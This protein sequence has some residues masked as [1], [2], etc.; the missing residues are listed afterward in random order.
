MNKVIVIVVALVVLLVGAM[1]Y[2]GGQRAE[3]SLN[4]LVEHLNQTGNYP[5]A[6]RTYQNGWFK[7][8]G[9]LDVEIEA[10]TLPFIFTIHHGPLIVTDGIKVSWFSGE[11]HLSPEEEGWLREH[12]QVTEEGPL[13]QSRFS[14]GLTGVVEIKD[15]G[16]P[17]ILTDDSGVISVAGYRGEGELVRGGSLHYSGRLPSIQLLDNSNGTVAKF[18]ELSLSMTSDIS[19]RYGDH[20]IPGKARFSVG[21]I[22]AAGAFG[23]VSLDDLSF[24]TEATFN[25]ERTLA[26]LMI[27]IRLQNF[28]GYDEAVSNAVLKMGYERISLSF[29]DQYMQSMQASLTTGAEPPAGMLLMGLAMSDLIP[30]GPKFS[31][32]QLTFS[33]EEGSLDFTASIETE[34]GDQAVHILNLFQSV[35]A[36]S[37]LT[38]DQ[39]LAQRLAAMSVKSELQEQAFDLGQPVLDPELETLAHEQAMQTLNEL[40]AQGFLINEDGVYS[41]QFSFKQGQAL[42]NEQPIPLPFF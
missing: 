26:D 5:V 4:E 16:K 38:V 19:Q 22:T 39:P 33:T 29:M 13:I 21:S 11:V 14:M 20:L 27:D 15:E 24:S 40:V 9:I 36:R 28:S 34:Q 17:F 18:E 3:Q 2:V 7:S 23:D 37:E 1:P 35:E 32:H 25:P 12:I 30:Y 8:Q 10:M 6:W 41:S 42:L 31:I